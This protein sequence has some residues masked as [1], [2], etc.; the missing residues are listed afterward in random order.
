MKL[1]LRITNYEL[2]LKVICILLFALCSSLY[3]QRKETLVTLHHA[4]SLIGKTLNGESVRELIGNVKLS[5]ENVIVTC[6]KATEFLAKK[7]FLLEGNVKVKEDS[8]VFMGKRGTYSSE[9]KSQKG[10]T[11]F[12]WKKEKKIL[13]QRKENIFLMNVKLFLKET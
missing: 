12:A 2:R 7:Y 4:D 11:A 8:V 10:L 5:Q 9:T 3:A 13:L 6:D 1:E